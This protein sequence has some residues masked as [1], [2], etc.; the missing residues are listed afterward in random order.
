MQFV[1]KNLIGYQNVKFNMKFDTPKYIFVF[2]I[3]LAIFLTSVYISNFFSNKKLESLKNIQED[4]ALDILSTETQFA[5]L[6]E[7]SCKDATSNLIS[8]QLNSL[9][10][11]IEYSEENLANYD[12]LIKLKKFYSLLQIKDFLLV[13]NISQRCKT[14]LFTIMYFYTTENKCTDCSKQSYVLTALRKNYPEIRVYSFDYDLDIL[15]IDA[16][17]KI[18]KID[19]KNLPAI[20]LGDE[21]V[22][23]FKNTEE[24]EAMLPK[25]IIEAKKN[26][27]EI[28]KTEEELKKERM[29]DKTS[30]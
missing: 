23:G 1:Q 5:L 26:R 18:Y 22:L 4:V 15:A 30:E 25:K 24:I 8:D 12:E 19:R 28:S 2:F 17:I 3:T 10:E 14:P 21:L 6:S 29:I 16:L 9:A 11:K 27:D 7:L 13:K 20:V